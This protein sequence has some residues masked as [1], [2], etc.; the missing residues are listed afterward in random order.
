MHR[1][2]VIPQGEVAPLFVS[3]DLVVLTLDQGEFRVLTESKQEAPLH[4]RPTLPREFI[5]IGES[6]Q[7]AVTRLAC[8]L[9]A[10][11]PSRPHQV[12]VFGSPG[13]DPATRV[14]GVGWLML[15]P[16]PWKLTGNR[17][18]RS[19]PD[20]AAHQLG[21]D[22]QDVLTAA[23]ERLGHDIETTLLATELCPRPF[24]LA[25]L[26]SVYE[27]VWQVRLDAANFHR[28]FTSLPGVLVPTGEQTRGTRG[29][30]ATLYLPGP[31]WRLPQR[32]ARPD[33]AENVLSSL[34]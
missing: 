4:G 30:P 13:R 22:H 5:A 27:V 17:Q 10:P 6:P 1:N 7:A 19:L 14:V 29:R 8:H 20:V 21:F 23:L 9:G 3:C 18:W 26:R 34:A 12:G 16:Q 28:K 25:Q 24:T 33:P 15:S 2:A 31:S 32:V 11:G